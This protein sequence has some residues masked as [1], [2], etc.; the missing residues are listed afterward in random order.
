MSSLSE[1]KITLI[2]TGWLLLAWG[3][4]EEVL[5][6]PLASQQ[7]IMLSVSRHFGKPRECKSADLDST[8]SNYIFLTGGCYRSLDS[9]SC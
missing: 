1:S 6:S 2:H 8:R 4:S 9:G 5:R 3:L 7:M